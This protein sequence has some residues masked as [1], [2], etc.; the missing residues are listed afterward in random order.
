M[1]IS[2]KSSNFFFPVTVL[3]PI[4]H[5]N[6]RSVIKTQRTPKRVVVYLFTPSIPKSIRPSPFLFRLESNAFPDGSVGRID[7]KKTL[8]KK[9]YQKSRNRR[10]WYPRMTLKVNI[11]IFGLGK[12]HNIRYKM[13]LFFSMLLLCSFFRLKEL[14]QVKNGLTTSFHRLFLFFVFVF[15]FENATNLGRSYDAKPA[16]YPDISLSRAKEGA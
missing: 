16:S 15:F 8:K 7:K 14:F 6:L 12:M 13:F 4:V 10:P 9:N 11:Y 5:P 2:P 1:L 3:H